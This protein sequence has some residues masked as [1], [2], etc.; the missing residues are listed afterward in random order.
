MSVPVALSERD[1]LALLGL[2]NG[3]RGED[4]GDGLPLS[5]LSELMA[6]VPSDAVSFFGLDSPRQQIWFGQQV[7]RD[8]VVEEEAA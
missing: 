1:L 3:H 6:Q 2:V 4:P 5:L 7:L 8:A